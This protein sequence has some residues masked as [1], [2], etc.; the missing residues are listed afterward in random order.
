MEYLGCFQFEAIKYKTTSNM[1]QEVSWQTHTLFLAGYTSSSEMATSQSRLM[2]NFIRNC[3]T[4]FQRCFNPKEPW[5][6]LEV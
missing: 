3:Q 2:F 5:T 4:V 1:F 6:P